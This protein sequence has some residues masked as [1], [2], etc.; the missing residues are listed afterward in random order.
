MCNSHKL[1]KFM[2]EIFP[3]T[4]IDNFW[5]LRFSKLCLHFLIPTIWFPLGESWMLP[6]S[7]LFSIFAILFTLIFTQWLNKGNKQKCKTSWKVSWGPGIADFRCVLGIVRCPHIRPG[8]AVSLMVSWC[9]ENR[10]TL[11]LTHPF[12]NITVNSVMLLC[13]PWWSHG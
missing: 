10:F 3:H 11:T 5:Y 12:M 1:V 8:T 13:P 2:P 9:Q 6:L 4:W 7:L